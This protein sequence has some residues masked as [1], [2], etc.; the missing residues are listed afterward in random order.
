MRCSGGARGC[1]AVVTVVDRCSWV[2]TTLIQFIRVPLFNYCLIFIS[3][4]YVY[5]FVTITLFRFSADFLRIP[6]RRVLPCVSVCVRVCRPVCVISFFVRRCDRPGT[7][8]TC[9]PPIN[10]CHYTL[11]PILFSLPAYLRLPRLSPSR[12][13]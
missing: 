7:I 6:L 11:C 10:L 4:S 5:L 1:S 12:P 3:I 8:E 13:S 2:Q 9:S